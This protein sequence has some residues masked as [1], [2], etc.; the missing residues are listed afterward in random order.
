[1][2]THCEK[3]PT[4]Y[5]KATFDGK[6]EWGAYFSTYKVDKKDMPCVGDKIMVRTKAG[7]IHER[8]VGRK[9]KTFKN[10]LVLQLE[11]NAEV[12]Q[13]AAERYAAKV[14]EQ[15][16]KPVS[17]VNGW[18]NKCQSYCYGDCEASR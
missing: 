5:S 14:G 4:N 7:E 15:V 12:A 18:C 9:N 6:E 11:P 17:P 2:K 13:N 1:M 3:A 10:Y 8:I 16:K